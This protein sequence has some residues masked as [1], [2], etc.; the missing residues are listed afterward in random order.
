MAKTTRRSPHD[1]A[2]T[3]QA[4]QVMDNTGVVEPPAALFESL[5]SAWAELLVADFR[6][7]HAPRVERATRQPD[8]TSV[9]T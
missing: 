3:R 2:D 6:R 9:S 8:L 7:R 5:V 4:E 1:A